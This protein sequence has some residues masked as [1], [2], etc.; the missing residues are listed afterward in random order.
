[1]NN[2][3]VNFIPCTPAPANGYRLTWRVAGTEDAYTDEG[4]FTSSPIIFTD[5]VNPEGTCYEGFLQSDCSES[6]ESGTLVGQA[7]AWATPCDEESGTPVYAFLVRAADGTVS[8]CGQIPMLVYSSSPSIAIGTFIYFDEALTMP[9]GSYYYIV[10]GNQDE[11]GI[12][13]VVSTSGEITAHSG[14]LCSM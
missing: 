12:I 6:G 4:L 8:I 14:I 2:V 1:M 3:T 10:E 7:V 11:P 9:V 13:Y 5:L